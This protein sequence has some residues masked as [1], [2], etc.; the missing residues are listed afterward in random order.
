MTWTQGDPLY[1]FA[2]DAERSHPRH[3][4]LYTMSLNNPVR[5]IDPDGRQV[6][7]EDAETLRNTYTAMAPWLPVPGVGEVA[8]AVIVAVTIKTVYDNRDA[9][10]KFAQQ[11]PYAT[12][13]MGVGAAPA[14]SV[15][16]WV[17]SKFGK[18]PPPP[19]TVVENPVKEHPFRPPFVP[20]IDTPISD[21]IPEGINPEREE[22]TDPLNLAEKI[23]RWWESRGKTPRGEGEGGGDGQG[24]DG[25]GG[26]GGGEHL[27]IPE[28]QPKASIPSCAGGHFGIDKPADGNGDGIVTDSEES[29]WMRSVQ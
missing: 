22:P 15:W 24:P 2:P 11:H 1:R 9:A 17:K 12:L 16:D 14:L 25:S 4:L 10:N 23:R 28:S 5:Y 6:T 20:S 8:A 27:R 13:A 21:G 3:S 7:A 18:A 26:G 19:P 29:A